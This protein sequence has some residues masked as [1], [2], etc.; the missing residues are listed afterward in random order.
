MSEDIIGAAIWLP[1]LDVPLPLGSKTANN[2]L[3]RL[4][5]TSATSKGMLLS[6][7]FI[8]PLMFWEGADFQGPVNLANCAAV[9][10]L[11]QLLG[12]QKPAV[13]RLLAPH[14]PNRGSHIVGTL[15]HKLAFCRQERACTRDPQ[16]SFQPL[17]PPLA[18]K[19]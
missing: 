4:M 17:A 14:A 15:V 10:G 11:N 1:R 7:F 9:P 3:Y 2:R 19:D 6:T 8:P 12:R 13:V 5:D 16:G 18:T